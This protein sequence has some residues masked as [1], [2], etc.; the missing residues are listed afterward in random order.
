MSSLNINPKLISIG[1]TLWENPNPSQSFIGQ[2]VSLNDNIENY[3]SY[4]VIYGSSYDYSDIQIPSG[5]CPIG[6]MRTGTGLHTNRWRDV[7]SVVGTSLTF[8]NCQYAGNYGTATYT[9]NNN[10]LI[11]LKIIGYK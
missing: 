6:K 5:E 9:D 4:Q 1:K 3:K 8:S 2:T 11:P 7:I 10:L